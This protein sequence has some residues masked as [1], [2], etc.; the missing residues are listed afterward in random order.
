MSDQKN[1]SG[2]IE[3]DRDEY[4]RSQVQLDQQ[5][6]ADT[7]GGEQLGGGP[8]ESDMGAPGG[9]S[10]TGGYGNDQN[11]QNH[12]G[13]EDDLYPNSQASYGNSEDPRQGRGEAFDEAQG[14]GRGD[15]SVSRDDS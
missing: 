2:G 9:S 12:Q 8:E 10:G 3:I 7:S 14:G 6:G 5:G 15:D 13:Q 4:G 11:S 1:Q